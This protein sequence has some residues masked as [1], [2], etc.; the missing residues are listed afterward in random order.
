MVATT[1][2][3]KTG[4]VKAGSTKLGS[5]MAKGNGAKAAVAGL[6]KGAATGGTIWFGTGWSLGLGLGLG[7]WGPLLL[8]GLGTY[9]LY[10]MG[11]RRAEDS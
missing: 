1:T 5:V 3:A 10:R 2:V 4:T 8:G 6:G 9:A 7:A 11:A